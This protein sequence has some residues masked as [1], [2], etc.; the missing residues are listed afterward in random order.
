M[1]GVALFVY[2]L[3]AAFAFTQVFNGRAAFLHTGAMI[4]TWMS[5]SVFFIIIPNQKKVVADPPRRPARPIRSSAR[6]PSSARRTT[7]T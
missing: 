4:A 3:L 1:L 5:A 2:I 7:T 6:R